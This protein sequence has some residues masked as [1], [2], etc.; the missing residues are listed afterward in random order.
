VLDL[1]DYPATFRLLGQRLPPNQ[2]AILDRLVSERIIAPTAGGRFDVTN[3]GAILF[4]RQLDQFSGL[5][6]KAIRLIFYDGTNRTK[7]IRE[8]VGARGYAIGF[9]GFLAYLN[10]FLPRNEHIGQ[11]LRAEE[12]MF[13]ELA[14][15][16][17]VANAL[18]HQDFSLTGTGPMVEVFIDRIEIT[19]PGV[20]L[21]S[22]LRF[23]DEPP[24]SRNE[25]LASVMRRLNICEERGSG[26]DKVIAEVEL[27]QLPAPDFQVTANHTRV[28]LQAPKTF[29][30][31]SQEERI[32]AC[33]QHTVLCW[34]SN[35][36]A[37]NATVRKR[38]GLSEHNAAMASR[39]IGDTVKAE[40]IKPADPKSTS[41]K[42]ASY[43][44][45]WE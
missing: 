20:P 19:N 31:M 10:G 4:A 22:P 5:R 42:F 44:P 23:I 39:I 25:D 32:R 11:A 18:I 37:T 1:I 8:Q 34:V 2:V 21:I 45:F 41:K 6:R 9:K 12:P 3:L 28:V 40:L 26:I 35:R 33:Y 30:A 14:I 27:Y 7:T 17:L 13:P 43:V 36:F 24:Q 16:E 29:A 38:F 15:R